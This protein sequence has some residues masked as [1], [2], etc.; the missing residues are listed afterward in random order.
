MPVGPG[1]HFGAVGWSQE[2]S[3]GWAVLR[4]GP[5]PAERMEAEPLPN[6]TAGS[7]PLRSGAALGSELKLVESQ[8]SHL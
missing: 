3:E 2:P 8:F 7:A 1:G 6:L 4:E 5:G